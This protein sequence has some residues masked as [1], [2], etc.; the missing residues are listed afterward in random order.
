MLKRAVDSPEV[1][2]GVSEGLT[3]SMLQKSL[4]LLDLMLQVYNGPL[5]QRTWRCVCVGHVHCLVVSHSG[6]ETRSHMQKV[7]TI[8]MMMT[9]KKKK[10]R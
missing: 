10:K 6:A 9:I 8:F 5:Q 7:T 3:P 1:L 4:T 2:I